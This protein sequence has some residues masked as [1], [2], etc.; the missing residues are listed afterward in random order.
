MPASPAR[1]RRLLTAVVVSFLT[2]LAG[3]AAVAGTPASA[4]PPVQGYLQVASVQDA[5]TGLAGMVA[6][7]PFAVEVRVLDEPG[8]APMTV[9][10]DTTVTLT[11]VSGPGILS[12]TTTAVIEKQTDRVTISGATY[13]TFGNDIVLAVAATG[14]DRLE[15]AQ[16]VVD[17][18]STAVRATASP[19]SPLDVTDPG[20]AAPT[21]EAPVCGYLQLPNGANGSVLMSVGACEG[22]L[23]CLGGSSGEAGLVTVLADLKDAAGDAL[24]GDDEPA[25]FIVACDKSRC[26]G[27]VPQIEV[28]V[29]VTNVGTL[30][31]AEPCPAKGTLGS[32]PFCLDTVQSKRDGAGDLYSYILFDHDIR[33]SYP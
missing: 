29:D 7:R 18:A 5:G 24:Y 32:L 25:T 30:T 1:S 31:T 3:L 19:N 10:R 11:E 27:G 12:G 22:V 33:A 17:A 23:T 13:S 21:P 6:G 2:A 20:C 8:G 9:N 15:S 4:G 14:G 26:Q 28:K 16:A